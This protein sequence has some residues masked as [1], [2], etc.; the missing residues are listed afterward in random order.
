MPNPI[1][2]K[3]ASRGNMTVKDNELYSINYD[4]WGGT[5]LLKTNNLITWSVVKNHLLCETNE[6][7]ILWTG[8]KFIAL[9]RMTDDTKN[10]IIGFSDNGI[11]WSYK[12]FPLKAH[13]P[14]LDL[15]NLNSYGNTK[16]IAITYRD[17]NLYNSLFNRVYFK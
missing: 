17:V 7:S 15:I 2:E 11:D 13:C 3:S 1:G 16:A 10:S 6:T 12:I 5:Y 9:F 8:S 14:T 4:L